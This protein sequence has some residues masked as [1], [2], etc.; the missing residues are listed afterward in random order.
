MNTQKFVGILG[1]MGPDATV[2]MFQNILRATPARSDQEHL[3][4]LIYNNP[5]IPDR[6][7]AICANGADPLPALIQSAKLLEQAGVDLIIIPCVTAHYFYDGLQTA[8]KTPI[9]HI[10]QETL[11]YASSRYPNLAPLAKA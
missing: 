6:T 5:K 10:A 11:Q 1:G 4:I 7:A 3:R 9:L 8:I 2:T